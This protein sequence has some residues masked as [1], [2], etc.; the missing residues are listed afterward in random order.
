MK[1]EDIKINDWGRIFFGEVP[2]EF[3][4]E[5]LI[6]VM[7][8]YL[9]LMVSM[10]LLGKRMASQLT[11]TELAAIVSLAAAVGVP[12]LSPDRGLLPAIVIAIIVVAI[13][14]IIAT[15]SAV[16]RKVEKATQGTLNILIKDSVLDPHA[17]MKTRISKE[18]IMSQLRAEKV[19]H[20]GEVERL[21][22]EANGNFTLIKKDKPKPGLPVLPE[23]DVAFLKEELKP[24]GILVCHICGKENAAKRKDALCP[25]CHHQDWVVAVE[26]A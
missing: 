7:F 1:P 23:N 11:R 15:L 22:M 25:N 24:N 13:N 21:Y 26:A 14:K 6:R 4:I 17:M 19:L 12:I 2:P 3:F 16:N 20:L 18:R 10:R 9:L 8:V 5:I